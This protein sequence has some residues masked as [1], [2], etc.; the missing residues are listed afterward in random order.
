[1]LLETIAHPAIDIDLLYASADNLTRQPIY[2]HSVAL[3][4]P[5]ALQALRRAATLAAAQGLRL[6]VFDAYRPVAAQWRLWQALPDPDYVADPRQGPMHSR[7]VAID[8]TLADDTGAPLDMG[9]GFD[10][11]TARSS[12]GRTDVPP[13]AQRNRALLLGLMVASGFAHNPTEWWHYQLPNWRDYPPLRDEV[14][15]LRLMDLAGIS[16]CA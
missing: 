8:L 16:H 14:E 1:M 12:H 15:G 7:G 5:H 2:Q 6:R 3:L 9:T 4:H 11:M 13:L 10:D